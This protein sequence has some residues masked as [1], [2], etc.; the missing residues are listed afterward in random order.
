MH[1]ILKPGVEV[2]KGLATS[3]SF[4]L[5]QFFHQFFR[6]NL[7]NSD[8]VPTLGKF[9]PEKP[10]GNWNFIPDSQG[11]LV[12]TA[13]KY[14]K[15]MYLKLRAEYDFGSEE[16]KKEAED[17]GVP[18]SEYILLMRIQ[19]DTFQVVSRQGSSIYMKEY[20]KHVLPSS[21]P[22]NNPDQGMFASLFT[23]YSE[24]NPAPFQ[25]KDTNESNESLLGEE[26]KKKCKKK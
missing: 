11:K 12:V 7:M 3:P 17:A 18:T 4:E 22:E 2:M 8:L 15:R 1:E 20:G 25:G 5:S 19:G 23:N 21:L 13:K 9:N 14:E 10:A 6:N 16:K 24:P 26:T